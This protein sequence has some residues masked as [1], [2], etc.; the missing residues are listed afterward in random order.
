MRPTKAQL[1]SLVLAR[2]RFIGAVA[3]V[4][5]R[6]PDGPSFDAMLV[7]SLEH[8]DSVVSAGEIPD[9]DQCREILLGTMTICEEQLSTPR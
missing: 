6:K 8:G 2:Y 7:R 3:M 5:D 4:I 1:E 9:W